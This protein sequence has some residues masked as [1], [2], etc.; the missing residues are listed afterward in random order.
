MI[1]GPNDLSPAKADSLLGDAEMLRLVFQGKWRL[2]VLRELL[3]GPRRL[4]QL[5]RAIPQATKKML[6]DTLHALEALHWIIR[7]EYD[8]RIKRV[9]YS[10][11][12]NHAEQLRKLIADLAS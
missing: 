6:I 10:I 7:R 5:R 11:S 2:P 9:E 4:S 1:D 12:V 8:G 3:A